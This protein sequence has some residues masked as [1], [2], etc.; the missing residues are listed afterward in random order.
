[1]FAHNAAKTVRVA[2]KRVYAIAIPAHAIAALPSR[3]AAKKDL[4]A[5]LKNWIAAAKLRSQLARKLVL[6]AAM[7]AA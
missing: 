5:A 1:V 7:L 6:A 3:V 4:H 2:V